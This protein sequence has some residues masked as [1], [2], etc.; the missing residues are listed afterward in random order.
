M[1]RLEKNAKAPA[2]CMLVYLRF[3]IHQP[4]S[5]FV[6]PLLS[7]YFLKPQHLCVP[8]KM[9]QREVKSSMNYLVYTEFIIDKHS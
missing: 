9:A 1:I 3:V 8:N 7:M 5:S 2:V 4:Q 6:Q